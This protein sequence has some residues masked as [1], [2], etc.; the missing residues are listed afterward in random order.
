MR[1]TNIEFENFR[2]FRD[3]GE[4]KCSTDGKVTI[5]YGKNGDGK[6]TLHQL[7]QWIIYGQVKFNKTTTDH[8]YNLAFESEQEYG[9]VF[10]VMGR[11]DFEYSVKLP[12]IVF[13][14]NIIVSKYL[15]LS[16]SFLHPISRHSSTRAFGC[17]SIRWVGCY[18]V[19]AFV[20][21]FPHKLQAVFVVYFV[22]LHIRIKSGF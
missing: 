3:H 22:Y 16:G 2:N 12:D 15:S 11:I 20:W 14:V 18:E 4:I 17:N 7:F 13:N 5:I 6:T 19:N 10:D 1:I 21:Q 8:L 9:K